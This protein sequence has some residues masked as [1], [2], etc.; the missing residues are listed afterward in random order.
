M[1]LLMGCSKEQQAAVSEVQKPIEKTTLT[2]AEVYQGLK[3]A[4]LPIGKYV[5]YTAETDSNKLLGRPGQYIGKVNFEDSR[6]DEDTNNLDNSIEVFANETDLNNRAAYVK[7]IT[8]KVPFLVQYQYVHKNVL[9]RL[10]K[11]L[12]PTQAS[13]YEAA[14]KKL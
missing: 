6:I 13:E 2:A 4:G 11:A 7:A 12:T 3:A 14:L 10:H 5:E 9:L 1:I 8:E